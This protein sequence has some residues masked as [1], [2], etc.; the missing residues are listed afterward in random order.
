MILEVKSAKHL[1]GFKLEILFS[2]GSLRIVDLAHE[3][4][5][6]IFEPLRDE[7]F[8]S[9]ERALWM[10]RVASIRMKPPYI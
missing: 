6:E 7:K 9:L 1:N 10:L 5:G 2:D 4:D 3:L 8:F